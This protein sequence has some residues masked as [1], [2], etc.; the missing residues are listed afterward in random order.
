MLNDRV[1]LERYA[2]MLMRSGRMDDAEEQFLAGVTIERMDGLP[3]AQIWH[4]YLAQRRFDDAQEILDRFQES[5]L[6]EDNLDIAFNRQDA[7]AIKTA[8]RTMPE[9][10]L[11][12]VNL[13]KPLLD[14]FDSPDRILSLLQAVY[15]DENTRWPR[16]LHDVS[17]VAAYF[18][19]PEFALEVKGQEV[20]AGVVRMHALW[21]PV[22]SEVR[23]L[24]EFKDFVTE[25]NLVEYWRAYGWADH[26]EPLG[27][28][29]FKCM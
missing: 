4:P 1:T 21:T 8:I 17:M 10:D 26:C 20:R 13:Y 14:E 7:E 29:D 12:F 9:T 28:N 18:G 23:R 27:E 15:R 5:D 25:M 24:P 6:F 19:F 3:H 16:K 11:A 2:I 22:M